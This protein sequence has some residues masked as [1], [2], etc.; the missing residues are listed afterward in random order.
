ML[1]TNGSEPRLIVVGSNMVDLLSYLERF[2]DSGETVFGKAFQQGF[3]GK[4]ANQAVMAALLGARVEIVTC[5]GDDVFATPWLNHLREN[6]IGTDHVRRIAD[7]PCGVAAIWVEPDG[8]NR[9][10][11]GS[12]ANDS[13]TES[14][15][16]ESLSLLYQDNPWGV[17]LCQLEVRQEAVLEAFTKAKE[18]GS[19]T[20]LNP[21]PAAP[22]RPEIIPLTDWLLPNETELR[23]LASS[24]Y[25]I[26][27]GSDDEIAVAFAR[28]TNVDLVVTLGERG[29]LMVVKDKNFSPVEIRAPEVEAV[30]TTGAGD[31][32]AGGFAFGIASGLGARQSVNLATAVSADSVRRAGTAASYAKGD[33]LQALVREALDLPA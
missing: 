21:G 2:P 31:A 8:A 9:I 28:A 11:L 14:M 33:A 5:V 25:G 16:D 27:A 13:L 6:G 3:G 20:I 24:M 22:L 1:V 15:V 7:T 18:K 32:F 19:V 30:D 4:G 17:V 26:E 23:L 12:G 10:V 29:S